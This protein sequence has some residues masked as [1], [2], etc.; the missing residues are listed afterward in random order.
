MTD[1]K[2]RADADVLSRVLSIMFGIAL[3]AVPL[4]VALA[5]AAVVAVSIMRCG[6]VWG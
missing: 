6:R 5:A 2:G 3:G 4:M 1:N